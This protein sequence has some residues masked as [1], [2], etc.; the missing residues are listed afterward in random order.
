MQ[1]ASVLTRTGGMGSINKALRRLKD[2]L[3]EALRPADAIALLRVGLDM[4][5][6]SFDLEARALGLYELAEQVAELDKNW[7]VGDRLPESF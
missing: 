6:Q 7:E 1:R 3:D 4:V 2:L 5:L